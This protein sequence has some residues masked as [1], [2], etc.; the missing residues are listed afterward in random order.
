MGLPVPGDE[1]DKYFPGG[2]KI[3]EVGPDAMRGRGIGYREAS[4][5]RLVGERIKGCPFGRP[6]KD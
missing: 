6:K 3:S 2:Y 4:K 5:E 1:G